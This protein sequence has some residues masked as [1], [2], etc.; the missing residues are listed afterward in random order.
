MRQ[1]RRR[2]LFQVRDIPLQS[3]ETLTIDCRVMIVR[4]I[5]RVPTGRALL[6]IAR[7]ASSVGSTAGAGVFRV[8][9]LPGRRSRRVMALSAVSIIA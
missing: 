3:D 6:M 2:R 8:P 1:R 4:V 5:D 9:F 7:N